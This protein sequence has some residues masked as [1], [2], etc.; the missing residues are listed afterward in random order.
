MVEAADLVVVG[1][2]AAGLATAIFAKEEAPELSVILLEGAKKV[3]AKI[4]VSGGPVDQVREVGAGGLYL[5][6]SDGL[7]SFATGSA[8][9]LTIEVTWRS[10]ARTVVE[11]EPNR[12][13]EITE[14][15]NQG[16][17]PA[18]T[19]SPQATEGPL[20]EDLRAAL[21]HTHADQHRSLRAVFE[22]IGEQVLHHGRQHARID[23]HPMGAG[24]QAQ[25]HPRP[26]RRLGVLAHQVGQEVAQGYDPSA[27]A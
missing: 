6:H 23:Q 26:A 25:L 10:G 27:P 21:A 18:P 9:S 22:A 14:V 2:G 7:Q 3:G 17:G 12:L 11:A 8:S 4:L 24:A 1:A 20:F 5:S 16:A 19:G 13:Y 15:L